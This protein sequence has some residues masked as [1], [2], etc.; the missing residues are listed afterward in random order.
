MDARTAVFALLVCVLGVLA[1]LVV[2][3]VLEYALAA[4]LLAVVLR[5]AYERLVPQLGSRVAGLALVGV[6]LV[7]GVV[8]LLLVSLVVLRTTASTVASFDGER[9][10]AY[11]RELARTEL[12]LGEDSVAVL[13]TV[14]RSEIEGAFSSAAELTFARTVGIVSAG[15]DAA[16]GAIVF[17]FL[18]Y[19]LLVD[20]PAVVDWLRTVAPLERRVLDG[21]L[22]E[23]HTVTWAVLR[24]HVFVAVVQGVLG[25]VG[26]ALLGVPYATTL[27]VILVLVSFLPTVGVWLVWGPVT[28]A[29]ATASG[30]V[31][32][33]LLLGYGIVVLAV[34]DNYLRALLV[35]R[36][37][38]LH[39]AVALVGVIGGIYLFGVLGLF[40]GPVVFAS[41]K[42]VLTVANDLKGAPPENDP[43]PAAV[44][45]EATLVETER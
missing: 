31:R 10:T 37:S 22:D 43:D 11:G 14:V 13:E 7:A 1:G 35:D 18:L 12:G 5:P 44:D 40:V 23:I 15:I 6:A 25:G 38:G 26:L 19:Y 39:P 42:A 33:S 32:G 9:I 20:G 45:R 2:L 8:P 24:S 41:F 21:L 34:V 28:V 29:H 16:I 3:P 27:A 30:L 17:V 4:C 36:G